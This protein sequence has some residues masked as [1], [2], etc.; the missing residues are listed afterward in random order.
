MA[1]H[2]TTTLALGL[3]IALSS[4][5]IN[6][7]GPGLIAHGL[8]L[9]KYPQTEYVTAVVGQQAVENIFNQQHVQPSEQPSPDGGEFMQPAEQDVNENPRI[10]TT[11]MPTAEPVQVT[12]LYFETPQDSASSASVYGSAYLAGC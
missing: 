2:Y 6:C 8:Y 10:L 5:T 9:C 11:N 1:K 7:F 3:F 12:E 4:G